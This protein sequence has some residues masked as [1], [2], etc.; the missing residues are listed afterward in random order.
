[1]TRV[2]ALSQMHPQH[3]QTNRRVQLIATLHSGVPQMAGN[4]FM[5]FK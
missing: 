1:L 5:Y 4:S 2:I 3:I